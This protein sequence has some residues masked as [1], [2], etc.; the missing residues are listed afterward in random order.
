MYHV[1]FKMVSHSKLAENQIKH[2]QNVL[3]KNNILLRSI[4]LGQ[5]IEM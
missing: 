5:S 1:L 3:S 4:K 2:I